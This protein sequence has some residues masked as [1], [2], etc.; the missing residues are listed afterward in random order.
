MYGQSTRSSLSTLRG[1]ALGMVVAWTLVIGLSLAW[2]VFEQR[3]QTM[4]L[5]HKEAVTHF[6]KDQAFRHWGTRHGG[7]YVPVTEDIQPNPYMEHI[8]ERDVMTDSGRLLTLLNPATMVR[9]LMEDYAKLYGVRGKITGLTVVNPANAPDAWEEKALRALEAGARE[10]QEETTI[11]GEPHLRLMRPMHMEEG[12]IK[13][14]GQLGFKVGDLRGAVDVSVPMRPYLD[15]EWKA[16]VALGGSHFL[17]WGLGLGAIGVGTRQIHRRIEESEVVA[18]TL[19]E[20]KEKLRLLNA[21]LEDRVAERTRALQEELAERR[22]AEELATESQQRLRTLVDNAADGIVTAGETMLIET[23]NGSAERI[24]G[25]TAK[26]VIGRPVTILMK[27]ADQDIHDDYV[28]HFLKTGESHIVGQG[29]EVTAR[30]RNGEEFPLYLAISV[31]RLGGRRLFTAIV[32]DLSAEKKVEA[33]LR[34]AK[35][36]AENANLAK[37]QFLSSMSHELRT[38]MNGILG[39][40]QLLQ[41]DPRETLSEH[42]AEYVDMILKAGNHLLGLINEVLDLSKIESG[43]LQLSIEAVNPAAVA[44]ECCDL[45]G[46]LAA[47]RNVKLDDRMSAAA[48]PAV[49]ADAVRFKQILV[50]L[51]SNAI[52]Y[53]RD[54]GRVV[55]DCFPTPAGRL[56][57]SVADTGR[58]IPEQR[59]A[60]LFQPFNRLGAE[61]G[62]IEGTGIGLTITRRLIEMMDG[63]IGV[64]SEEGIGSTFWIELPLAEAGAAEPVP[65]ANLSETTEGWAAIRGRHTILYVEDNTANLML[66]KELLARFPGVTMLSAADAETGIEIARAHRP[67]LILMD[68]NLPGMDGFAAL[69]ELRRHDETHAIPVMA[70]SAGAMPKDIQRGLRAGFCMYLTKPLDVQ[71]ALKAIDQILNPAETLDDPAPYS[72]R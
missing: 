10:V 49:M 23:F 60:E 69:R 21:D 52:K 47:K 63:R 40:A 31:V 13:C 6:N 67:E 20:S 34:A 14:H 44:R 19:R 17:I 53:N 70:L 24:F 41:F 5:G 15:A 72:N 71:Q 50:N 12:C 68:I 29:R 25:Y 59:R 2:N 43:N 22:R 7:V 56:R 37:S 8:P 16:I 57:I 3:R 11:D 38:P 65:Q 36:Q 64:E 18:E 4:D 46:P 32:R 26:E 30:R 33:A 28:Q 1:Y 42:Q 39:F 61:A 48:V 66:M 54:G 62:E 55:L 51:A 27:G 45:L 9:Q 35:V 58:G